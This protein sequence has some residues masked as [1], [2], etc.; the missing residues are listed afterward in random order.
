[1]AGLIGRARVPEPAPDT[2]LLTIQARLD[3]LDALITDAL[4]IHSGNTQL[5]DFALDARNIIRPPDRT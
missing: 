3:Q 1:M 5:V 2:R 4:T